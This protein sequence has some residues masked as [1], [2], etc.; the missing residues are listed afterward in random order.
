MKKYMLS[1]ALVLFFLPNLF[2]QTVVFTW[3]PHP[4]SLQITGF[5][6]Y[7]TKNSGTYPDPAVATY[8]GGNLTTGTIPQPA[9]G[10]YY[11]VLTA[12]KDDPTAG[13][14][15]SGYSNEVSIVLKPK[16]PK[17]LGAVQ[18]AFNA[19]KNSA[20]Y[21]A[22]VMEIKKRSNLKATVK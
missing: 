3:D 5:K 13:V 6:L 22:E 15:E 2:A 7:Q 4:E 17:L 10:R 11:F 20:I 21:V 16:P 19:I 12:Y 8:I 9:L 1:L 14:L 18:T